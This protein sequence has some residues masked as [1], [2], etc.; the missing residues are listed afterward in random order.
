M[1]FFVFCLSRGNIKPFKKSIRLHFLQ[2]FMV[3]S[4]TFWFHLGKCVAQE[5]TVFSKNVSRVYT[6]Y[7][8]HG[9]KFEF[10]VEITLNN[11]TENVAKGKCLI[12]ELYQGQYERMH[13]FNSKTS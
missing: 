1:Y 3:K 12:D 4:R 13:F 8:Y 10:E 7:M 11:N 5:F 9:H 2:H 6:M